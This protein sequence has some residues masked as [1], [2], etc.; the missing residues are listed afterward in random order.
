MILP[1]VMMLREAGKT[2][3]KP[4]MNARR[5]IFLYTSKTFNRAIIKNEKISE[6]SSNCDATEFTI[7]ITT[8]I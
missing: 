8:A 5:K 4:N 6:V 7:L 2:T 3:R 1:G